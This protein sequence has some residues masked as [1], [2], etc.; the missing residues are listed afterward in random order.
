MDCVYVGGLI[1]LMLLF[2]VD[3][4][5]IIKVLSFWFEANHY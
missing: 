2:F 1:V 4:P 5:M 3:A